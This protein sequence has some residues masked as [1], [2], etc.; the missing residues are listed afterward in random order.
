MSNPAEET[1]GGKAPARGDTTA[2]LHA[3][4]DDLKTLGADLKALCEAAAGGSKDS[5]EALKAKITETA[6][7]LRQQAEEKAR[8]EVTERPLT[9]LGITFLVGYF[10]GAFFRRR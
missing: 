3:I 7:R 2:E 10:L 6:K 4:K 1:P 5:L 9:T 8:K